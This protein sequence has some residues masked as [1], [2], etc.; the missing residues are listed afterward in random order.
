MFMFATRNVAIV[1]S[2]L[3]LCLPAAAAAQQL[4]AQQ[5]RMKSCNTEASGKQL[6]G[7]ERQAYMSRC[8]KGEGEEKQLTAQQDKMVSCNREASDKHLRGD[9]R[10]AYMSDCLRAEKGGPRTS[11]AGGR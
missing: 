8:L 6:K 5:E 3:A 7:D 1:V 4:T 10:R 2:A 11:A 9:Q